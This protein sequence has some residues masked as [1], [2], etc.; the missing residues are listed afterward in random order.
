MRKL[1]VGL[2][3]AAGFAITVSAHAQEFWFGAGPVA[4]GFG[5]GPYAYDYGSYWGGP[6]GYAPS[7]TYS[8]SYGDAPGYAYGPG[9]D[10]S[11]GYGPSYGYSYPP[12]YAY[13]TTYAAPAYVGSTYAYE[14]E[15]RYRRSVVRVHTSHPVARRDIEYRTARISRHAYGAQA[16]VPVQH[17]ITH[18]RSVTIKR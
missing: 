5:A 15:Y 11:V 16:S 14:P 9:F 8:Y 7:Y 6:Y 18:S 13:T 1:A 10:V 12:D 3:A 4:V 2:L 17:V